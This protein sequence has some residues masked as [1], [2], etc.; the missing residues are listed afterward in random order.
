MSHL[1]H[2]VELCLPDWSG[3]V[4]TTSGWVWTTLDNMTLHYMLNN[5]VC[6]STNAWSACNYCKC[7]AVSGDCS[8]APNTTWGMSCL[9]DLHEQCMFALTVLLELF[10]L[11]FHKQAKLMYVTLL[12]R[13]IQK[14]AAAAV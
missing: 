7:A 2:Q 14:Q 6:S 10:I 5:L 11:G 13:N 4:W 12:R 9:S 1:Q 3:W 8:D